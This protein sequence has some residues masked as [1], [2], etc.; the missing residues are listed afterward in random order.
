LQGLGAFQPILSVT[1]TIEMEKMKNRFNLPLKGWT[2]T[3][4]RLFTSKNILESPNNFLEL[5][6]IHVTQHSLV[7]PSRANLESN[8]SETCIKQLPI[9]A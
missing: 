8:V 5:D 9:T 7:A 3:R 2:E 6:R 1:A 4:D